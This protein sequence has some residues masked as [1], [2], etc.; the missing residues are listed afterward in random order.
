M[1]K[2]FFGKEYRE[3]SI[4]G[5]LMFGN[6]AQLLVTLAPERLPEADLGPLRGLSTA[7]N[8][9]EFEHGLRPQP[10][11]REAVA[12]FLALARTVVGRAPEAVSLGAMVDQMR[13][14]VLVD[15]RRVPSPSP[16]PA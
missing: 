14:P 15:A 3:R 7:R 12:R 8:R 10:P 5:P 4:E 11:E 6:G 13:F 9:C 16:A 2:R 1:G